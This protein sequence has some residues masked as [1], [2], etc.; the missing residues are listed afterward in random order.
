MGAHG[1]IRDQQGSSQVLADG[2]RIEQPPARYGSEVVESQ[3]ASP[4]LT[5]RPLLL[6]R[7]LLLVGGQSAGAAREPQAQGA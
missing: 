7:H 4:R 6:G 2:S 3:A 1:A 5:S